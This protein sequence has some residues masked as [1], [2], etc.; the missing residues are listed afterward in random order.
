MYIFAEPMTEEQVQAIQSTNEAKVLELERK[1]LGIDLGTPEKPATSKDEHEEESRK[2]VE[3]EAGVQEAIA[4][5]E[6]SLTSSE[7]HSNPVDSTTPVRSLSNDEV[8]VEGSSQTEQD[9]VDGIEQKGRSSDEEDDGQVANQSYNQREDNQ[10]NEVR[11]D[12][13]LAVS[14]DEY[15]KSA[16]HLDAGEQEQTTE[17][18][19]NEH[20]E[21]D[22]ETDAQQKAEGA[23]IIADEPAGEPAEDS[24]EEIKKQGEIDSSESIKANTVAG[25]KKHEND[26]TIQEAAIT[27]QKAVDGENSNDKFNT[28]AD[29][30]FVESLT[31]ES[32]E[33]QRLDFLAM[34]LTVCNKVNGQYTTRPIDLSPTDQ[35]EV[36]YSLQRVEDPSRADSLYKACQ[37]RRQKK[38]DGDDALPS[39]W[40][41]RL[42]ILSENG[43]NWRREMDE[44]DS[45]KAPVVFGEPMELATAEVSPG[46]ADVDA[47]AQEGNMQGSSNEEEGTQPRG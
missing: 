14:L 21:I 31:R 36:E 32:P 44:Q 3:L 40:K 7:N 38:F 13:E 11:R 26:Q 2:W 47:L 8:S 37:A 18:D 17:I 35:W 25:N 23:E 28:Q 46:A 29:I 33:A 27:E 30:E 19:V 45:G 34:T 20:L 9:S 4:E 1:L 16:R 10:A 39:T 15:F 43:A 42:Q 12:G 22:E 5:D 6:M 24:R 41:R